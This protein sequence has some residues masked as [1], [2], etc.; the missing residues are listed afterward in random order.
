[1]LLLFLFMLSRKVCSGNSLFDKQIVLSKNRD[2]SV[3]LESGV[4]VCD[5]IFVSEL[6][7][8]LC[9]CICFA[10]HKIIV[11]LLNYFCG[12]LF[13]SWPVGHQVERGKRQKG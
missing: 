6:C 11:A 7:L 3:F 5:C 8:C 2:C 4:H 12:V 10:V 13:S 1:M 9:V